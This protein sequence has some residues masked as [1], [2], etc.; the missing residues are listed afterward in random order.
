MERGGKILRRGLHRSGVWSERMR[1]TTGQEERKGSTGARAR[2][3]VCV[4]VCVNHLVQLDDCR[5]VELLE[6]RDLPAQH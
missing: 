6:Q 4:H 2:A 1:A 3:C 5:V